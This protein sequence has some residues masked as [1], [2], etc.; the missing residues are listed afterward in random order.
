VALTA[1]A[2][3]KFKKGYNR[4]LRNS[5]FGAIAIHFLIFYFTPQFEFKPYVLREAYF[6][7]IDLPEQFDIP[8]PPQEVAQPAIPM[9]AAE[10]EEVDD[11]ADIAPTTFDD[12]DALPPPPPPP[13]EQSQ[14]FY[15]FDEPPV[16]IKHISPRYPDLARQAGIEG[17]VLLRVLVGKDGKVISASVLQSDVTPMMEKA[18]VAAAKQFRF[19]PAKQ[20]TV[21]VK[22]TMMVPIRFK[23]HGS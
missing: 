2:N 18:A 14:A 10:G 19:K 23:L 21:P 6:E 15:A 12:I 7:A 20:R 16:L 4:Y 13:S 9:E 5:L 8:P 11:E 3:V 1:V 22:A 17:T